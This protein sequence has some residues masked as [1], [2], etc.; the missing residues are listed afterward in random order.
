[1]ATKKNQA[2][3]PSTATV[4]TVATASMAVAMVQAPMVATEVKK[5]KMTSHQPLIDP[6][7][8]NNVLMRLAP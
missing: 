4:A 5:K 6:S 7:L 1:M 2:S 8:K 3:S